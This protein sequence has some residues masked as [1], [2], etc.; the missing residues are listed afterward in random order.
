MRLQESTCAPPV[1]GAR[2]PYVVVEIIMGVLHRFT[3]AHL[4]PTILATTEK[5]KKN[6]KNIIDI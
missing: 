3:G 2:V 1:P 6:L 4:G 5:S